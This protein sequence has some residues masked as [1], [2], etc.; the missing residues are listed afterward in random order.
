[1]REDSP[2]VPTF[3]G[4]ARPK[5]RR[6]NSWL[7]LAKG[8]VYGN[9]VASDQRTQA[10]AITSAVIAG[11]VAGL[12]TKVA[13]GATAKQATVVGVAFGFAVFYGAGLGIESCHGRAL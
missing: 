4:G 3:I 5:G 7:E 11:G 1:V 12:A 10:N 9:L 2:T 6:P 8:R 13:L